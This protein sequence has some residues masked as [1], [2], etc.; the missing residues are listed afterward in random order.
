VVEITASEA[1]SSSRATGS[2]FQADAHGDADL[3]RRI[4]AGDGDALA[5]LEE[6]YHARLWGYISRRIRDRQLAEE[7]EQDVWLTVWQQADRFR[8]ESRIST[9]LIGIAH[10]KAMAAIRRRWPQPLDEVPEEPSPSGWEP[11]E[12]VE[13]QETRRALGEAMG[14]LS[15][16]HRATLD[17]VFGHGL[18]LEEVAHV[19]DC[20]VGTVKSRLSYARRYLAQYLEELGVCRRER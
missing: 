16:M 7:V 11:W 1:I 15:P 8:G 9:W 14:R 20:P 5:L 18:S 3:L 6:R 12:Q 17:L 19:M 13:G 10:H 2:P 4:A